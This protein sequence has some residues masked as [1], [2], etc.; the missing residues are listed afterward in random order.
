MISKMTTLDYVIEFLNEL[1]LI[2]PIAMHELFLN[3]RVKC[4]KALAHHP[5]VQVKG[6]KD[7]S[8]DVGILGILNGIFGTDKDG[9]G[10][11]VMVIDDDGES[12]SIQRFTGR[13]PDGGVE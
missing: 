10:G 2:D 5:S 4:N 12:T 7:G 6:H 3:R 8:F 9:Y 13:S 11:I 1:I